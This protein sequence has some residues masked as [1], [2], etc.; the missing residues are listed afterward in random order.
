MNIPD[1]TAEVCARE[2]GAKQ[3]D[4]GDMSEIIKVIDDLLEGKLY[5]LI[6]EKQL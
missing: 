1:F 2:K 6:R 4:I 5:E 3:V